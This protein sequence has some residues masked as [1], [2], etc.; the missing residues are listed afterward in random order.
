LTDEFDLSK[1][2]QVLVFRVECQGI[3]QW[4]VAGR[5][6]GRHRRGAAG[7]AR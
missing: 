4:G 7:F 2:R 5:F 3:A 6:P 1:N